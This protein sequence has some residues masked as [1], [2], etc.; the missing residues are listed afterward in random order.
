[1]PEFLDIFLTAIWGLMSLVGFLAMPV[2]VG[3]FTYRALTRP[4]RQR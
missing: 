2:F 4:R 3:R 1:M